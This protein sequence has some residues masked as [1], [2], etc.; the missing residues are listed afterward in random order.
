MVDL[1]LLVLLPLMVYHN[2]VL[3]KKCNCCFIYN[4]ALS[5]AQTCQA[6]TKAAQSHQLPWEHPNG[7]PL[8]AV[9]H[10]VPG[11][12]LWRAYD[13]VEAQAQNNAGGALA[14]VL[15]LRIALGC[16]AGCDEHL[17]APYSWLWYV[18]Q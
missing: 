12:C 14:Q 8:F 1:L 15:A 3:S 18:F 2:G 6:S 7:L 10:A 9:V 16:N 11:S 13:G 5:S 17:L 4:A